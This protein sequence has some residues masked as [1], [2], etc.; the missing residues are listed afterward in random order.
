[1][2]VDAVGTGRSPKEIVACVGKSAEL[3]HIS[4][5]IKLSAYYRQPRSWQTQPMV[6]HGCGRVGK[7]MLV[8][9]LVSTTGTH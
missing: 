4:V 6:I 7:T 8:Q 3:A 9:A 5:A 1:M 2:V